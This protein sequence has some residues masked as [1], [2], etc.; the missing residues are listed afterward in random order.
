[1]EIALLAVTR[2]GDGVCV[3]GI[4]REGKWIRPTRPV[5]GDEGWRCIE[6]DDCCDEKG[7][8][9]LKKGN[10]VDMDLTEPIPLG[11]R[12][13]DWRLGDRPPRLVRE[14]PEERYRMVCERFAERNPRRLFVKKEPRSLMLIV[15]QQIETF[16]FE[17]EEKEGGVLK[18]RP[19]VSFTAA[20]HL[21]RGVAVTDAE[22]RG[23]GREVMK[24]LG[25]PCA[26]S[27]NEILKRL[28]VGLIG[29]QKE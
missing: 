14:L 15:P 20:D 3:A 11:Y 21:Y 25:D 7:E 9:V 6:K 18:Y 28:G 13:E 27:G 26:M 10:V 24:E 23:Y 5:G 12:T 16:T 4:T 1:M 22:W 2:L 29:E 17:T 8:W 19:R